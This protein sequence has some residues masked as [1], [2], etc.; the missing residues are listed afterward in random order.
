MNVRE[1]TAAIKSVAYLLPR[2][3]LDILHFEL[4]LMGQID[5]LAEVAQVADYVVASPPVEWNE[6]LN[7]ETALSY[8]KPG[9]PVRQIVS[10]LVKNYIETIDHLQANLPAA[11][12]AYDLS[13][14]PQV[15]DSLRALTAN[16]TAV[17][18]HKYSEITSSLVYTT[19][20]TDIS[21]DLRAAADGMWSLSRHFN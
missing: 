21:T 4:C 1:F 19:N 10:S 2:G 15:I 6:G 18:P 14:M 13:V 7:Y 3:R 20:L 9:N 16:L 12:S 5:V 11:M 17:I 8:F